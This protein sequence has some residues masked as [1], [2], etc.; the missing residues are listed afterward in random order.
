MKLFRKIIDR[1]SG[2]LLFEAADFKITGITDATYTTD[3][4]RV[5]G[6]NHVCLKPNFHY[7]ISASQN[8]LGTRLPATT[9]ATAA[10]RIVPLSQPCLLEPRLANLW[11]NSFGSNNPQLIRESIPVNERPRPSSGS[12]PVTFLKSCLPMLPSALVLPATT[13]CAA[14]VDISDHAEHSPQEVV[15]SPSAGRIDPNLTHFTLKPS[16]NPDTS[17]IRNT[18]LKSSELSHTPAVSQS[19]ADSEAP[20]AS[21]R[22]KKPFFGDPLRHLVKIIRGANQNTRRSFVNHTVTS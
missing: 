14:T 17:S 15:K 3:K 18:E 5:F 21:S 19:T 22:C 10:N 4:G 11:L 9:T 2:K 1:Q 7:D 6:K 16:A 12:P 13:T 8:T 20:R